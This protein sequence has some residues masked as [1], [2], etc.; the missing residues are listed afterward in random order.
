[1]AEPL[2]KYILLT[3]ARKSQKLLKASINVV[4]SMVE[5]L[6]RLAYDQHG[7]R[8]KLTRAIL[9]CPWERHF[10]ALS[11]AYGGLGK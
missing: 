6:R 10:M 9:L 5:W 11:P 3:G 1:M 2:S 4:S 7:L 8:S